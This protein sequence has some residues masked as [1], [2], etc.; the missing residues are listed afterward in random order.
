MLIKFIRDY[1]LNQ[2]VNLFN[3]QWEIFFYSNR[4]VCIYYLGN[5]FFLLWWLE[6]CFSEKIGYSFQL[7]VVEND[8]G[9]FKQK[10]NLL[11]LYWIVFG[12]MNGYRIMFGYIVK[13]KV[14]DR[15][16]EVVR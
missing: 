4:N 16:L 2:N 6:G 14:S 10:K 8:Y 3:I 1:C 12:I 11:K 5:F 15:V 13:S 9:G 7:D